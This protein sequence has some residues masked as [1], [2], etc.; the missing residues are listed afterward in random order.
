MN[1]HS[2][3]KTKTSKF[4]RA[5]QLAK[6]VLQAPENQVRANFLSTDKYDKASAEISKLRAA[7]REDKGPVGLIARKFDSF[8]TARQQN[9][10]DGVQMKPATEY[11]QAGKA[12]ETVSF[13]G[14]LTSSRAANVKNGTVILPK[15][16]VIGDDPLRANGTKISSLIINENESYDTETGVGTSVLSINYKSAPPKNPNDPIGSA[17]EWETNLRITPQGDGTFGCE[18]GFQSR[19]YN[20]DWSGWTAG[21][22]NSEQMDNLAATI[23]RLQPIEQTAS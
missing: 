5:K 22:I 19:G 13:I 16:E 21:K 3:N 17:R 9:L 2:P 15:G 8:L 23:D 10:P 20:K 11:H 12:L 6:L 18:V 7:F 14:V 1:E 4:S